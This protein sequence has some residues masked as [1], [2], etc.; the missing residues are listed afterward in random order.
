MVSARTFD[1]ANRTIPCW[2]VITRFELSCVT[3]RMP[4]AFS[5]SSCTITATAGLRER[6]PSSGGAAAWAPLCFDSAA[7][8]AAG[9]NGLAKNAAGWMREANSSGSF[10]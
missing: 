10:L 9:S 3:V 5:R 1:W 8:K 6:G 2:S 7:R 4:V